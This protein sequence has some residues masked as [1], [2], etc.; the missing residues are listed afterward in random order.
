MFG[1]KRELNNL[2]ER[3]A[4]NG[5]DI[6]EYLV[7]PLPVVKEVLVAYEHGCTK[8]QVSMALKS[9]GGSG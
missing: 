2:I 6:S 1:L 9:G 7:Y 4:L 5:I 3:A 8:R